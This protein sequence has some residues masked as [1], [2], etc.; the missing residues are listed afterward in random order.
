MRMPDAG[1]FGETRFEARV[2]AIVAAS[3]V[4]NPAGGWVESVLTLATQRRE[5]DPAAFFLR[6]VVF[7]VLDRFFM[8]FRSL[9]TPERSEIAPLASF[10]VLLA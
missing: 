3:L 9:A 8:G 4:N 10:G 6:L 2:R 7:E 1:P 5:L